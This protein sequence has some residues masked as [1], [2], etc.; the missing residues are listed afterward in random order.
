MAEVVEPHR[1]QTDPL[2]EGAKRRLDL[3]GRAHAAIGRR[4][5]EVLVAVGEAGGQPP[6]QLST[7]MFP[8]RADGLGGE[9]DVTPATRALRL[10]KGDTGVRQVWRCPADAGGAAIEIEVAPAESEELTQPEARGHRDV[11]DGA[12]RA[13]IAGHQRGMPPN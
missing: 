9:G 6:L 10:P 5:D 7:A 2:H 12:I 1:A 8:E 3:V 13:G 11:D 4:E